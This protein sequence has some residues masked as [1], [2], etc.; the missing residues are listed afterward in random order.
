VG[1]KGLQCSGWN[2][3]KGGLCSRQ[4]KGLRMGLSGESGVGFWKMAL[5]L[6]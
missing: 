5:A 4:V 1:I 3:T 6:R 2:S